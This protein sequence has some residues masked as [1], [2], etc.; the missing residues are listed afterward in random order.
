MNNLKKRRPWTA[1]TFHIDSEIVR[2][3]D[4][5]CASSGRTKTF[6]VEQALRSLFEAKGLLPAGGA[7]RS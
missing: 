3:L 2:I 4:S 6:V 1:Q 5:Y 7:E